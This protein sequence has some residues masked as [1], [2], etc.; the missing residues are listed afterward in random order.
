MILL[1]DLVQPAANNEYHLSLLLIIIFI[2]C[3][4]T[5]IQTVL[6]PKKWMESTNQKAWEKTMCLSTNTWTGL[7]QH[8]RK[9][10]RT[11]FG[12]LV[13]QLIQNL[14]QEYIGTL[15]SSLSLV[16]MVEFQNVCVSWT[17][18]LGNTPQPIGISSPVMQIWQ[19]CG[20]I[21]GTNRCTWLVLAGRATDDVE[22]VGLLEGSVSDPP[23]SETCVDTYLRAASNY[24]E[25][26]ASPKMKD[27]IIDINI[28]RCVLQ[29][30]LYLLRRDFLNKDRNNI[31]RVMWFIPRRQRQQTDLGAKEWL[32]IS[33]VPN[34]QSKI[35]TE[36]N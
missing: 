32:G 19:M 4:M 6:H 14:S 36:K 25:F 17:A 18:S 2:H 16:E 24:T 11:S 35:R 28:Y 7:L 31:N 34:L 13:V 23:T 26:V 20:Y 5:V 12:N 8:L 21:N 22:F 30:N 3:R 1:L 29:N 33:F 10:L 15:V 9:S 27:Y